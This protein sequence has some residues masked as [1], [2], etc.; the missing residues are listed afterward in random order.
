MASRW[1]DLISKKNLHVQH[2]FLSFFAVVCTITM[3]FCT[4]K[5]SNFLVTHYFYGGIVACAYQIFCFL[6]SC[7]VLFFHYPFFFHL[8][9]RFL[10]AANISHFLTTP[11]PWKFHTFLPT[12]F[13]SFVLNTLSNSFSVIYVSVNIRNNVERDSTLLLIF[14]SKS[15]GDHTI[16]GQNTSSCLWCLTC[17]L[18]YFTLVCLWCGRAGVRSRDCQNLMH[19]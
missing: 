15:P 8:A 3:P 4:T 16:S 10:L 14:L 7:S 1:I 12:K 13:V 11:P 19:F 5:T 6:C 9:G 17:L 18:S 2:L